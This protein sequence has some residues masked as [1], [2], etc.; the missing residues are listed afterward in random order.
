MPS[1]AAYPPLPP[2]TEKIE[3]SALSGQEEPVIL[4]SNVQSSNT[5]QIR[6]EWVFAA[7]TAVNPVRLSPNG[8]KNSLI[9]SNLTTANTG[10][11]FPV[12]T[13]TSSSLTNPEWKIVNGQRYFLKVN[14]FGKLQVLLTVIDMTFDLSR[15]TTFYEEFNLYRRTR[16]KVALHHSSNR[17]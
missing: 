11:Y 12:A 15:A 16:T 10:E 6:V 2:V 1:N 4:R 3:R 14:Y 8:D 9:L 17:H 7:T 13:A 5:G